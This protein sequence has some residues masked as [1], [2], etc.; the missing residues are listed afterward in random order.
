[1]PLSASFRLLLLSCLLALSACGFHLR[2]VGSVSF[3]TM[4]IQDSGAPNIGRDLKRSIKSS[5]AKVVDSAE[6]AQISLELMSES[7]EKRILSLSGTGRVREYELLYHVVFRVRETGSE[8]WSPPQT[9]EQRR[10]FTY[11]DS[12]VL[13]K[14]N[15]E[16]RLNNDMR[17]DAIREILRRVSSLSKSN[18][19]SE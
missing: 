1:M 4:Y 9:V 3:Q 16:A 19:A 8:L 2:G 5:G 6:K 15:E 17:T 11:N 18:P 12:Q 7:N 13:A 10:D 14:D